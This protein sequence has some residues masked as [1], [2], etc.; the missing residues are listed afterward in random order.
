MA[1]DQM[2][3]LLV[4]GNRHA[5]TSKSEI[6]R[7][8]QPVVDGECPQRTQ[9]IDALYL[10]FVDESIGAPRKIRTPDPQ[11]RSLVL[12]PAELSALTPLFSGVA[13][14]LSTARGFGKAETLIKFKENSQV[15]ALV[16]SGR[17]RQAKDSAFSRAG[18][19]VQHPP[20]GL[21]KI[22][23]DGQAKA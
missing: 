11:I 6:N 1:H 14:Y 4:V 3:V 21:R 18:H 10:R 8:N 2:Q 20:V 12:Y 5:I 17:Q 7:G 13:R 15:P 16:K 22:R 23:S 9:R 19:Q